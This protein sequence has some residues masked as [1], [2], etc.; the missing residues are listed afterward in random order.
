MISFVAFRSKGGGQTKQ[1]REK[2][3]KQLPPDR[4]I[5]STRPH[6]LLILTPPTHQTSQELQNCLK[7]R[8][9]EIVGITQIPNS[10]RTSCIALLQ[11]NTVQLQ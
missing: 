7:V 11:R 5:S 1:L 3:R 9:I 2:E 8:I 6:L 4:S 10:V